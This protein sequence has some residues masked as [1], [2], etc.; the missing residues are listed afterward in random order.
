MKRSITPPPS[1][2]AYRRRTATP[3]EKSFIDNEIGTKEKFES[4]TIEDVL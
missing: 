2:N 3:S 1:N 4:Q